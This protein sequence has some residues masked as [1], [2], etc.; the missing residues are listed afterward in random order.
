MRLLL[1]CAFALVAAGSASADGAVRATLKTSSTRAVVG[2]PWTYS[3]EV[4]G[5]TDGPV[6]AKIKLQVLQGARVVRCWTGLT[7]DR[8]TSARS[9]SWIPFRGS[10]QSAIL[11]PAPLA[12]SHV[13]FRVL[14]ATGTE[15]LSLRAPVSVHAEP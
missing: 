4:R 9:G 14:V 8:C 11:W 12:G 2:V 7:L 10:R 5:L 3:I 15:S 13:T 1:V 6:D